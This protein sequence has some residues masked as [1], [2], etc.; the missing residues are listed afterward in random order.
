MERPCCLRSPRRCQKSKG[1]DAERLSRI[2]LTTLRTN[3]KLLECSVESILG[4]VLQSVQLGLEPN[5]LGSCHFIPY[6]GQ[7]SFQIG[8]K[9]LIDLATLK[10]KCINIVAQDVRQGETFNYESGGETRNIKTYSCAT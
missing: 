6:K 3:P 1:M 8:Y 4:A 2:T 5:L 7:V 10:G 9:G